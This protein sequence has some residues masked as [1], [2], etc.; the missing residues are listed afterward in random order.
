MKRNWQ[1]FV[2]GQLDSGCSHGTHLSRGRALT[3]IRKAKRQGYKFERC[4]YGR[5][6]DLAQSSLKELFKGYDYRNLLISVCR[7]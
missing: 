2:Y 4:M 6:I 1:Y 7:E 5:E 3:L